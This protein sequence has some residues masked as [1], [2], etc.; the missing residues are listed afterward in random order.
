MTPTTCWRI[1]LQTL[2]KSVQWLSG[3]PQNSPH[4][5]VT[6]LFGERKT[7]PLAVQMSKFL[8]SLKFLI[9]FTSQINQDLKSRFILRIFSVRKKKSQT[10]HKNDSPFRCFSRWL[11]FMIS[12]GEHIH[13]KTTF[14]VSWK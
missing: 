7:F 3:K 6:W 9:F 11:C 12:R 4:E 13:K 5:N 1:I 8:F 14:D 2:T 10:F